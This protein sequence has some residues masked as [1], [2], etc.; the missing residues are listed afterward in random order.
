MWLTVAQIECTSTDIAGQIALSISYCAGCAVLCTGVQLVLAQRLVPEIAYR[1]SAGEHQSPA[2]A[3]RCAA[4]VDLT[5]GHSGHTLVIEC[6]ALVVEH[7]A[8]VLQV[9]YSFHVELIR[10]NSG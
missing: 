1:R 6:V 8:V 4:F 2:A 3:L 9:Q 5:A 10:S 7:T